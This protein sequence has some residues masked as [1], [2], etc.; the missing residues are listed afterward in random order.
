MEFLTAKYENLLE[1]VARF[2][3]LYYEPHE[4]A[5]LCEIEHEDF[6]IFMDFL[7]TP[8]NAIY[9]AYFKAKLETELEIRE[10]IFAN[11]KLGSKEDIEKVD[12]IMNKNLFES[13][14]PTF[15]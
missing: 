8:G 12:A 1:N 5:T 13:D 15:K 10:S 2:G 14:E 4:V 7:N 9:H 3:G 6:S 11:A